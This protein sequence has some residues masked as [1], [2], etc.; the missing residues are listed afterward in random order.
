M[1]TK[2]LTCKIPLDL[3]NRISEEIKQNESTMSKFIEQII[4]EHYAKGVINMGKTRTMAF[5]VSEELFQ[6]IKDYLA[7]YEQTY[8]RRLS[9]KEFVISLIEQALAEAD[10][11]FEAAEAAAAEDLADE[12]EDMDQEDEATSDVESDEDAEPDDAPEGDAVLA[13]CT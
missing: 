3:H 10:E 1:E 11:E 8:H 13:D 12:A 6:Q 4:L 5:Q 9:Q 7:R 2:G